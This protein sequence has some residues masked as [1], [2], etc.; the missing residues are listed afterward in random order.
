MQKCKF[1]QSRT[2]AKS[3]SYTYTHT[4][5]RALGICSSLLRWLFGGGVILALFGGLD[6]DID[7]DL[8]RLLANGVKQGGMALRN[9]CDM[10]DMLFNASTEA[11]SLLVTALNGG[12]KLSNNAQLEE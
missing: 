7:D 6:G 2:L 11:T 3:K 12:E 4:A 8:R 5:V 9:P 10:S 1:I